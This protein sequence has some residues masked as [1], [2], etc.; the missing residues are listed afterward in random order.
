MNEIEKSESLIPQKGK[1]EYFKISEHKL[2][3]VES[4]DIKSD[5]NLRRSSYL[6]TPR[7]SVEVSEPE[8]TSEQ[9]KWIPPAIGA[10]V[11]FFSGNTIISVVTSKVSGLSC[12]FYLSFGAWFAGV[13]F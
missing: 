7:G 6:Q 10:C 5:Q 1:T 11:F 4:S 12:I 13:C 8:T 9:K 2:E 3:F